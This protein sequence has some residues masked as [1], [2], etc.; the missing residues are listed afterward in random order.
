MQRRLEVA[1]ELAKHVAEVVLFVLFALLL[2]RQIAEGLR[3]SIELTGPV[4]GRLPQLRELCFEF[5][6]RPSERNFLFGNLLHD[7]V[8]LDQTLGQ[9]LLQVLTGALE[10]SLQVLL[11]GNRLWLLGHDGRG[12]REQ[13][14][15]RDQ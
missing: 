14:R 1:N 5:P 6:K 15:G 2:G 7:P 3:T 12:Q 9:L 10:H 13:H 4:S 8:E 11:L